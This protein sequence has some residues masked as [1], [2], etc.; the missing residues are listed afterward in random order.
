[1]IASESP[2]EVFSKL[3]EPISPEWKEAFVEQIKKRMS[4]KELKMLARFELLYY[5]EE[6]IEAIKRVL[7]EANKKV[8]EEAELKVELKLVAPP[9]Y[10]ITTTTTSKS[11]GNKVLV[12]ALKTI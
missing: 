7:I 11:L 1:M 12:G 10:E 4:A 5:G 2:D 6:G 3:K 9:L 8:N